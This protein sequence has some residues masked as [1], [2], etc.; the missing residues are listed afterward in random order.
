MSQEWPG[1]GRETDEL[2]RDMELAAILRAVDPASRDP[3]Y[4]LRFR[5]WVM[6]AAGPELARRRL[7]REL[8]VGDMLV[9]WAR[10]VVPAAM[11]AAV[12]AALVLTRPVVP[13]APAAVGVEELLIAGMEDETIPTALSD[14]EGPAFVAY[15]SETF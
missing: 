14:G 5:S 6:T 13:P 1:N 9:S 8:T 7:M 3:N 15:A 2:G 12:I 4:W 11:A 10:G